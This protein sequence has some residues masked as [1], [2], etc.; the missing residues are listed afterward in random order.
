[1]CGG[2]GF[3]HIIHEPFI[4]AA[5]HDEGFARF[6]LIGLKA[7]RVKHADDLAERAVV[8]QIETLRK[9][10]GSCHPMDER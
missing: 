5:L 7:F 6:R 10:E 2:E 9:I 3:V 8:I 1:M 4:L